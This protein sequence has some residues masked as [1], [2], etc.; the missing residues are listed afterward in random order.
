MN[1]QIL[2]VHRTGRAVDSRPRIRLTGDW[3]PEMGFVNSSLV[4]ALPEPG[5]IAFVLRNENIRCYSDLFISTKEKG[6]TLFRV[7]IADSLT[8]KG[9]T[10]VATGQYI[11]KGGLEVGDGLIAKCEHGLIRVRKVS[12][13]IRLIRVARDKDDRTG[14]YAPKVWLWDSD[15]LNGIGFTLGALVAIASEPGCIT[16]LAQGKDASHIEA[17]R[18]ARQNK[19]RLIQVGAKNGVMNVNFS[20]SLIDRAGFG[21]GDIL[22]A[23]YGCGVIK[24]QKLDPG[25]FG[26]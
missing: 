15:W 8:S 19:M 10:F 26:F 1:Y 25:R 3:L 21:I 2:S 9:P 17:V 6:G 23:E 20:G 24:L 5:G 18:F 16:L 12:G 7:Y 14:A 11:L 4:Q 22:A 13:D